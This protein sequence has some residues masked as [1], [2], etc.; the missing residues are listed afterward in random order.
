MS[1]PDEKDHI[2]EAAEKAKEAAENINPKG[3]ARVVRLGGGALTMA[4]GLAL[5]GSGVH[6]LWQNYKGKP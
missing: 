6:G 2:E 5:V 3:V 4:V 1:A